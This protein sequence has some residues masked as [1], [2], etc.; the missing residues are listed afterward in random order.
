MLYRNE[1][2]DLLFESTRT[3]D[4]RFLGNPV[5]KH[6][7]RQIDKLPAMFQGAQPEIPIFKSLNGH[8]AVIPAILFPN[9]APVEGGGVNEVPVQQPS[10]IKG[11]DNPEVA[12][13]PKALRITIDD[14]YFWVRVQ[15]S[16]STLKPPRPEAVVCIKREN[17]LSL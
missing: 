2:L 10:L 13:D 4:H 15:D 16:N 8:R 9:R 7:F 17:I 6:D 5:V 1:F 14:S 3:S 11:A 12:A